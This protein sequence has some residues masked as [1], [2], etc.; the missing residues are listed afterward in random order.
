MEK[1]AEDKQQQGIGADA[2]KQVEID[3]T[4]YKA[5][6]DST[7]SECQHK[8]KRSKSKHKRSRCH[9]RSRSHRKQSRSK[10]D[11]SRSKHDRN[12]S[13]RKKMRSKQRKSRS[14][15]GRSRS[16]PEQRGKEEKEEEDEE[17]ERKRIAKTS[18]K[19]SNGAAA[20]AERQ[21]DNESG[22]FGHSS[23]QS[24]QK[25][26]EHTL[27][28]ARTAAG[29]D[30]QPG[31][32]SA[33]SGRES[34]YTAKQAIAHKQLKEW[35]KWKADDGKGTLLQY[36][37]ALLREFGSKQELA[38]SINKA[39]PGVS[40]VQRVDPAVFEALGVHLL[41]HKLMLVKAIT[42]LQREHMQ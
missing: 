30:T 17:E 42:A 18:L 10:R 32:E 34:L 33:A 5:T 37:E 28:N 13:K 27:R 21:P 16:R 7:S 20:A 19:L 26:L 12:R 41:G 40:M 8:R 31:N 25:D 3:D 24:V 4:A 22:A 38:A 29:L 1:P 36:S 23:P 14:M 35:L 2:E 39:T 6:E 9:N 11:R 15:L